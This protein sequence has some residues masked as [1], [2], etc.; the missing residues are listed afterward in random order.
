MLLLR[1][2]GYS[3]QQQVGFVEGVTIRAKFPKLKD[4]VEIIAM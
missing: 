2:A 1:G 3:E 4:N